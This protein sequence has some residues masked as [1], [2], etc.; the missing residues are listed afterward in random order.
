M[1]M[2]K[3]ASIQKVLD[4][5]PIVGADLIEAIQVLG[6]TMISKK[7]EFAVGDM[8]VMFEV[9][10]VLPETNW[11]E[12]L[13][14]KKFRIKTMK[15]KGYLSQ[16]LALPLRYL[17]L[18]PDDYQEGDDVTEFLGVVKHEPPAADEGFSAPNNKTPFPDFVPKT[19][20]SR[21]QSAPQL[22]KL[23]Q[24]RSYS[25]TVKLDGSSFT[26]TY[27]KDG[28]FHVCSRNFS[29]NRPEDGTLD[30]YWYVTQKYNLESN[31]RGATVALQG[32]LCG[33]KI[34]KN[35]LNLAETDLFIFNAY[36]W[37]KQRHYSPEE[38]KNL[39]DYFGLKHVPVEESGDSFAYTAQDL[40]SKADGAY[41]GTKNRREGLVIRSNDGLEPRISFKAISN[42]FLLKEED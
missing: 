35:R 7:G 41:T 9:D 27:D 5:N 42:E 16:G 38:L 21:V 19:D 36:D 33:P 14:S 8:C 24:G 11:S 40:L 17:G 29:L 39:C 2:R 23:L 26:A 37:E 28:V 10:S 34:Q 13:R 20:E 18:S 12:F 30:K 6:W 15:M 22:L 31:L 4:I 3:L 32:E 25:I 1:I